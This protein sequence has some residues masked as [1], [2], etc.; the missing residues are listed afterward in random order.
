CYSTGS[1]AGR[2]T[3][4]HRSR[5]DEKE[6]AMGLFGKS[7]EDKVQEAVEKVRA[8]VPGIIDLHAAVNDK[9]VTLTGE[10]RTIEA[11]GAAIQ[12]FGAHVETDNTINMIRLSA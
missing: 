2:L 4:G 9:V 11:K 7:F 5:C 6:D 3:G 8:E 12:V 1:R 10:A